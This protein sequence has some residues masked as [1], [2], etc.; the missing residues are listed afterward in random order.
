MLWVPQKGRILQQHNTGT[1]GALD[2]GTTVTTA[3]AAGT[4]GTAVELIAST[5][6]DA[7]LLCIMAS[8][9]ALG[10]TISDTMLDILIGTA[11]EEILIPN[12]LAGSCAGGNGATSFR[13]LGRHW[14]FPLYIPAGSRIAAQAA[15]AR[16]STAMRVA[17]FLFGGHGIPPFRV[18]SKVISYPT[19]PAVPR[20]LAITPGSTGAEG[21]W[22][23]VIA[24]TSEGHF[25]I[26]PSFQVENDT[27]VGVNNYALDIGVGAATEEEV[28]QSYWYTTNTNEIMTDGFPS[29]PC[30]VDVPSGTRLVARVSASGTPEAAYGVMLHC[31]S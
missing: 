23:E 31:V 30:F 6:F 1:V 9:M 21:A 27:S 8:D 7:Y 5:N 25:A 4:K 2:I 10:A 26:V 22:T 19:A 14:M 17:V 3:S 24:S 20:G 12:L 15:G 11:T 29:F 13:L 16:T 28:A 18:G